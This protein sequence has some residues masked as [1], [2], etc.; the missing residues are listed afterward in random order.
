MLELESFFRRRMSTTYSVMCMT[1]QK[2]SKY[3]FALSTITEVLAQ[4]SPKYF[5][6][7][8]GLRK[9]LAS[10]GRRECF[11]EQEI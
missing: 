9:L 8:G 2:S 6:Y 10:S 4:Q 11:A 7:F 3:Q 1:F 5:E